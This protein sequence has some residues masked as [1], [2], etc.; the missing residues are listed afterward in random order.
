MTLISKIIVP[1]MYGLVNNSCKIAGTVRQ[2]L[3][4]D[5]HWS[6][7][8][9]AFTVITPFSHWQEND[10]VQL[11]NI[12]PAVHEW[13]WEDAKLLRSLA[14]PPPRSETFL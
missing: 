1:E 3:S 8:S 5:I 10:A 2:S 7:D 11:Y 12:H 14:V 13:N 6:S 4:R 9:K